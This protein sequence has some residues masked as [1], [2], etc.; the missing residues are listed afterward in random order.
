MF[1]MMMRVSLGGFGGVMA[2]MGA[3]TRSAMGVMGGRFHLVFFIMTGGL[4]VMM[5]RFFMMLGGVMMMLAG[6]MLVRHGALPL[7]YARAPMAKAAPSNLA[8][9]KEKCRRALLSARELAK[10]VR[11]TLEAVR[12]ILYALLIN[13]G[14]GFIR[15]FLADR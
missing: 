8:I 4:A 6:G 13:A 12:H 9:A 7:G 15:R 14:R 1:R 5:R 10:P 11:F 2:G 3:M